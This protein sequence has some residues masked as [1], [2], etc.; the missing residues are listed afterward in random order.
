M[1]ARSDYHTVHLPDDPARA[2]VWREIAAHLRE[3]V[4][5]SAHVLEI[6]AGY[7]GW[8]NAVDAARRVAVDAWP[9]F[10]QH[11]APGVETAVL[12]LRNGLASLAD[13]SLD[14]VLASNV[15]EHFEPD[16]V[17]AIVAD[18]V[19]ILRRNGRLIVIQPNFRYAYRRYFDDYT[20]R[21]VFTHVSLPNL[22]RSHGVRIV[23]LEPRFLPY[24]MRGSGIG[25]IAPG[26]VA[27]LVRAYL[28]SPIKPGAGQMLVVAQKD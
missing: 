22:L 10:V 13:D 27:L 5:S 28:T 19:R 17:D 7:C 15:L 12:D 14:V 1:T 2:I 18:A 11:A 20:H 16:A 6:G 4:G 8:I 26:L 9:G 23:R 24:S 21:S 25:R 3:W